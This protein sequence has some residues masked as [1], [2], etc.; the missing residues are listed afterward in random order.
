MTR[1]LIGSTIT[2]VVVFLPLIAVTG[3]TGSFFRALAVTMTAALLTSLLLALTWTPALSMALLRDRSAEEAKDD[4]ET[5]R[6]M[7][8]V[9]HWHERALGWSLA[10]PLMLALVCILLVAGTWFGYKQLGS[11]LLPAMDEGGFVLDYIMPAGSSLTE[12]DR[13]LAHVERILRE[14]A[15]GGDHVAAHR[16]ADGPRRGHGGEYRRHHGEAE[17]QAR[18]R[19]RRGDGRMCG[20]R[21][22]KTEPELDVE[23]T[24]VL[25]D[26]IGDLS[27]APEPIQIKIFSTDAALLHRTGAQSRRRHQQDPGR[28]RC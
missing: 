18:P 24:Q 26:M 10:R 3:V 22:S 19:H 4:A 12:T 8:R 13:V 7:G 6:V 14:H 17:E 23:F 5:G 25:Q 15:G 9:L 1:P 27:N 21:S 20:S 28:G 2:P 11:D 16:A